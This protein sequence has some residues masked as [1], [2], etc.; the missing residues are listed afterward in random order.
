[1]IPELRDVCPLIQVF[2]MLNSAHDPDA[3]RPPG[4]PVA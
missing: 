3:E 2:G 1:M 4:I